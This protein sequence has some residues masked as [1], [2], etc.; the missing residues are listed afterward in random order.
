MKVKEVFETIMI[1]GTQDTNYYPKLGRGKPISRE[2]A[3]N[4][5]L[6]NGK[7]TLRWANQGWYITR[8]TDK[9]GEFYLADPKKISKPRKSRNTFDYY[10]LIMDN[11]SVW[12]KFPKRSLSFI[13][14]MKYSIYQKS[15]ILIPKD[16][17]TIADIG[18]QDIWAVLYDKGGTDLDMHNDAINALLFLPDYKG[19][20]K[21]T[22]EKIK[23][24]YDQ[25]YPRFVSQC[26]IFDIWMAENNFK[27]EED[28]LKF[29][30]FDNFLLDDYV[31]TQLLE[32]YNGDIYKSIVKK[33]FNPKVMGCR[34]KRIG[35][36]I[37]ANNEIWFSG[38]SVL[39]RGDKFQEIKEELGDI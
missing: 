15:Y 13:C 21:L 32:D 35:T 5:I 10:T 33:W 26:K 11:D 6:K 3:L 23:K 39:I 36:P 8:E 20:E 25:N 9:Q 29:F 37:K 1:G 17:T 31:V 34:T 27:Y 30:D 28:I 24:S 22:N 19:T 2:K 14:R 38:E 12:S 4:W 7:N 18:D 16:G